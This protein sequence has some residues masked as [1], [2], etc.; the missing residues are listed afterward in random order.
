MCSFLA[1][2]LWHV[3][4]FCTRKCSCKN[5]FYSWSKTQ[6]N[7][8]HRFRRT[9]T[10]TWMSPLGCSGVRI[11]KIEGLS[12]GFRSAYQTATLGRASAHA[13]HSGWKTLPSPC[14]TPTQLIL[15]ISA[16]V[17]PPCGYLAWLPRFTSLPP[18][19]PN[20]RTSPPYH[21][22][23][24]QLCIFMCG[25]LTSSPPLDCKLH[26]GKGSLM[27]VLTMLAPEPSTELGTE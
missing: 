21:L 20:K 6:K 19:D 16:E 9:F 15:Q 8:Y 12:Q 11:W 13:V 25:Y 18:P 10:R 27:F 4:K 14:L 24:L 22:S 23:Q 3:F 17:L 7:E 5:K 26:K 2:V 1:A